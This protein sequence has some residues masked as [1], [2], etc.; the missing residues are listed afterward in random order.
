MVVSDLFSNLHP[1]CL[2]LQCH[3]RGL[4]SLKYLILCKIEV[5][6]NQQPTLE[7][8]LTIDTTLQW[9]AI[10]L[11]KK[12]YPVTSILLVHLPHTIKAAEDVC[13]LLRFFS[14]VKICVGNPDDGLTEQW[15]KCSSSL[16]NLGGK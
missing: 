16:H 12:L 3:S 13:Y 5:A 14:K 11:H 1:A 2:R 4:L 9:T 7:V 15:K 10:V 8:S 6:N